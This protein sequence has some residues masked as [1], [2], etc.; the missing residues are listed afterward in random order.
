[1]CTGPSISP[2][3]PNSGPSV[4]YLRCVN[5]C[6]REN[7]DGYVWMNEIGERFLW[8]YYK[9]CGHMQSLSLSLA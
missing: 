4:E 6:Y 1:M 9:H 3:I 2:G 7:R 8:V 5:D